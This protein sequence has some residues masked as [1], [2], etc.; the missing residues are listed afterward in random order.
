MQRSATLTCLLQGCDGSVGHL[1]L[2]PHALHHQVAQQ[3][4]ARLQ[5]IR[6]FLQAATDPKTSSQ[7]LAGNWCSDV[8]MHDVLVWR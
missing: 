4:H 3:Q 2:P 8:H 5:V 7:Q 1:T 6:A